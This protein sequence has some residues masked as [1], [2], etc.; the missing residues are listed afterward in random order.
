[1]TGLQWCCAVRFAFS[2][3]V[4][5]LTGPPIS[6]G[7]GCCSLERT[8]RTKVEGDFGLEVRKLYRWTRPCFSQLHVLTERRFRFSGHALNAPTRHLSHFWPV[9]SAPKSPE[10]RDKTTRHRGLDR[11]A[12][13][14]FWNPSGSDR[15]DPYTLAPNR[16]KARPTPLH[17]SSSST[18][19]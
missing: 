17:P 7:A 8:D 16:K 3:P 19:S 5:I 14:S 15:R 9:F 6:G 1:M 12:E 11:P 10:I 13:W 4:L 2:C 18:S